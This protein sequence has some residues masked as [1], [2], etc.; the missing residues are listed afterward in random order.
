MTR[1]ELTSPVALP[2]ASWPDTLKRT[3]RAFKADKLNHWGAALTYYA[4]LSLFPALLVLVSLVGLFGSPERITKVLTDTIS[5]LGPST[6]AS[7]FQ[8]PIE[9]QAPAA[10]ARVGRRPAP[11]QRER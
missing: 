1:D 6:A 11:T 8:G 5:E 10:R 3:L 2:R 4:V 7:T 9:A